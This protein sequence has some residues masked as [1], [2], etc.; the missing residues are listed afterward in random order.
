MQSTHLDKNNKTAHLVDFRRKDHI[1]RPG[2]NNRCP[3]TINKHE[4]ERGSPNHLFILNPIPHLLTSPESTASHQ[5]SSA[6][7]TCTHATT[8]PMCKRNAKESARPSGT[9]DKQLLLGLAFRL[10]V[11]QPAPSDNSTIREGVC[12]GCRS[13]AVADGRFQEY[14]RREAG[15][16]GVFVSN[17]GG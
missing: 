13:T 15:G 7:T 2:C 4:Q 9:V 17:G 6:R 10:Q 12:L 16:H 3:C 14:W 1:G 8:T 5:Y 11:H